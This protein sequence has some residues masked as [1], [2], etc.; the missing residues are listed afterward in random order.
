MVQS[1]LQFETKEGCVNTELFI[2]TVLNYSVISLEDWSTFA[3]S[4]NHR[5]LQ[6]IVISSPLKTS[7]PLDYARKRV[8]WTKKRDGAILL[9][10]YSMSCQIPSAVNG[11]YV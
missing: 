7:A 1:G 3:L 8:K 6:G 5:G 10:M 4:T 2:D 11:K 9:Y